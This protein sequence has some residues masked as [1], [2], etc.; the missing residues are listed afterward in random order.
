MSRQAAL[1]RVIWSAML[2]PVKPGNR[3]ANSTIL[4]MH[5]VA[6]SL[7]LSHSPR[8]SCTRWSA[9]EFCTNSR[10]ENKL[11]LVLGAVFPLPKPLALPSASRCS[12]CCQHQTMASN[13]IPT[14]SPKSAV[15]CP[16]WGPA[17]SSPWCTCPAGRV[18]GRS[19]DGP[20]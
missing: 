14:H 17:H 5:L 12:H 9:L 4:M 13:T 1:S 20:C 11:R 10:L 18:R 15:P 16:H 19:P 2:S 3:L 6:S 7:N 8:S